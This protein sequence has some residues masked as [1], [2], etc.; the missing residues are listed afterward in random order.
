MQA[1]VTVYGKALNWRR[2][3]IFEKLSRIQHDGVI[4]NK[5]EKGWVQIML[6]VVDH[7]KVLAIYP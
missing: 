3:G 1:E 4:V 5:T 2:P 7:V 6:G